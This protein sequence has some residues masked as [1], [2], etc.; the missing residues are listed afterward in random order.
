MNMLELYWKKLAMS[1]AVMSACI[2]GSGSCLS[3]E[4]EHCHEGLR[5][6][7]GFTCKAPVAGINDESICVR[8]GCGDG[9]VDPGEVCDD[10]DRESG[11]GCSAD[12]MSSETCGN[13]ITDS[14]TGETCDCT[15][16]GIAG[17]PESPTECLGRAND[18]Q[19]G[20]CTSTCQLHC[21]DQVLS[22]EEVCEGSMVRPGY[23]CTDFGYDFGHM[24]CLPGCGGLDQSDCL[25]FEWRAMATPTSVSLNDIWGSSVDDVYAVGYDGTI[26][27]YDGTS[28][29]HQ[30]SPTTVRLRGVWGTGPSNVYAVGDLGTI[31]RYDGVEWKNE[32]SGAAENLF[33]LWGTGPEGIF[34]VGES[35]TILRYD[36]ADWK[37]ISD[38][39]VHTTL[40]SVWGTSSD[41][42]FAVGLFREILHYD[43]QTWRRSLENDGS[44]RIRWHGIWGFA[45]DSVYV[46]GE[47]DGDSR[48]MY[49]DGNDWSPPDGTESEESFNGVWGTGA[50]D[51]FVAGNEG[52][53]QHYDGDSW[54]RTDVPVSGDIQAIWGTD[55]EV[56]AVGEDG[57]LV[58]MARAT[59]EPVDVDTNEL[60]RDIWGT[61]DG[62]EMF[63]VGN[64]GLIRHYNGEDWISFP[65]T[66]DDDTNLHSVWGTRTN[67]VWSVGKY[68]TILHYDGLTWEGQDSPTTK[69]LYGLWGR[70]ADSIF[71]VGVDGTIIQYENS[72]WRKIESPTFESLFAIW[73]TPE[74]DDIW[75]AGRNGTLV[76][77]DGD[78]W[79]AIHGFASE[80]LYQIWGTGPDNLFVVGENRQVLHLNGG[81][82]SRIPI[83]PPSDWLRGVWGTSENDVFVAGENGTVQHYD[84]VSWA[85]LRSGEI[86][87]FYTVWVDPSGRKMLVG[88]SQ[89][90]VYKFERSGISTPVNSDCGNGIL[91]YSEQCDDGSRNGDSVDGGGCDSDCILA[92]RCGDGILQPGENCDDG[93]GQSGDGCSADC[94]PDQLEDKDDRDSEIE[95][96]NRDVTVRTTFDRMDDTHMFVI[97]NDTASAVTV[98]LDTY[99]ADWPL[100]VSCRSSIDT[101]IQLSTDPVGPSFMINDNR[102]LDDH[103]SRV[104]H[105]LL[106]GQRVHA[107]VSARP[108]NGA[109]LASS[110]FL[111]IEFISSCGDGAVEGEEECEPANDGACNDNCQIPYVC[112][113]D[114]LTASEQCDDGNN[115]PG[116]GCSSECALELATATPIAN[117]G[118]VVC[119]TGSL[120]ADDWPWA[121]PTGSCLATSPANHYF[122]VLPIVNHTGATQRLTVTAIWQADG[123]LHAYADPFDPTTVSGCLIGD[124]SFRTNGSQIEDLWIADGETL[125]I[126]ASPFSGEATIGSYT[127][128]VFTQ[129]DQSVPENTV[130]P[131]WPW[132]SR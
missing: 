100:G 13:G 68:G 27:H 83:R 90:R 76:H 9:V 12:C 54:E 36:G 124:D 53:I 85:T 123:H 115:G 118:D 61:S 75:A 59:W 131:A 40:R 11:D 21:G 47:D 24:R 38:I 28:W 84:G 132:G 64:D 5:C 130:C 70:N 48:I 63:L 74:S 46:V 44:S 67:N 62:E 106:P 15:A 16:T 79:H 99:N 119:L 8:K 7:S 52:F 93:N 96:Y 6:P 25:A 31:L 42:V 35:G 117:P 89:G 104:T 43:G 49:Y 10:G 65:S 77:F 110:Y 66:P 39:P 108:R 92:P 3:D 45:S 101:I 95:P 112:G 41:N 122:D 32:S 87:N 51:I 56:F 103:C 73:G 129:L 78:E 128:D 4:T 1:A 18:D 60:V 113:D 2:M 82:W 37:S 116:D 72:N 105:L 55:S 14:D 91:E 33:E 97:Q 20:L 102:T 26:I 19:G 57:A 17:D 88:G 22:Q 126:V 50:T 34:V 111:R 81:K 98:Q 80:H 125:H 94:E 107:H 121:R 71:A 29:E 23:L 69:D 109:K 58:H 114:I 127:I 86:G 120:D 30:N